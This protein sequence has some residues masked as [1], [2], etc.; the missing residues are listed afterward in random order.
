MSSVNDDNYRSFILRCWL[1]E[2]NRLRLRVVDVHRG[3]DHVVVD[4]SELPALLAHLMLCGEPCA[5]MEATSSH[6][7]SPS[8][9][10]KDPT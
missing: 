9:Q 8:R 5:P 7:S 4:L 2:G 6:D 10:Q 1:G 3:T